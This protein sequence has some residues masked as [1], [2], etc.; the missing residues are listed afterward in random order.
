MVGESTPLVFTPYC[1]RRLHQRGI[2]PEEVRSVVECRSKTVRPSMHAWGR[3][4]HTASV[5][6]RRI[7]VVIG[8]G[9]SSVSTVVTA[10]CPDE[11][12]EE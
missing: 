6:G 7:S 10:W 1:L 2:S 9:P 4:V 12:G 11:G 3:K 8:P 5:A